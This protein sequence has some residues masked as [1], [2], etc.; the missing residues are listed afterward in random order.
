VESS[1]IFT[2]S[3]AATHSLESGDKLGQK[4]K[5]IHYKILCH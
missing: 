3:A 2:F 4:D 5:T 1:F